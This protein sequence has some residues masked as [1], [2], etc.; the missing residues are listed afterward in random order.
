MTVGENLTVDGTIS[1]NLSFDYLT[2]TGDI[3]STSGNISATSGNISASTFTSTSDHRIKEQV[4]P[5]IDHDPE[6]TVDKLNPVIYINSIT[7]KKDMGFIAHELQEVY[8]FLVTGEKDGEE[9]QTVN[10]I[11]LI[12]LLVKEI[13]ELKKANKEKK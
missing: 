13:K 4:I 11:G 5:I 2:V 7:N 3:T 9:T 10:Y 1:G 12:A 8:P 6:L